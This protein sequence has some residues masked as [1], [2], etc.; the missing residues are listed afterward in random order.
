MPTPT[1]LRKILSWVH[2][3][4]PRLR[5]PRLWRN[6]Q[7]NS[8][9]PSTNPRRSSGSPRRRIKFLLDG[10]TTSFRDV[11]VREGYEVA[12]APEGTPHLEVLHLA[13]V[14]GAALLTLNREYLNIADNENNRYGILFLPVDFSSVDHSHSKK[15]KWL[16]EL[17]KRHDEVEK[18][19]LFPIRVYAARR[20]TEG[21]RVEEVHQQV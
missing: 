3:E 21:W 7:R 16:R 10:S 17:L 5:R 9:Q 1:F 19:K 11:I 8:E 14:N 6:S 2:S 15:V 12:L 20:G 18:I 4:R 13:R